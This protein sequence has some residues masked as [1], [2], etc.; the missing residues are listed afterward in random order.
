MLVVAGG[1]MVLAPVG[2]THLHVLHYH[3]LCLKISFFRNILNWNYSTIWYFNKYTN[4]ENTYRSIHKFWRNFFSPMLH[5]GRHMLIVCRMRSQREHRRKQVLR[6]TR[7]VSNIDT[8]CWH[9][10]MVFWIFLNL[11]EDYLLF[12]FRLERCFKHCWFC[13]FL[14]KY[15][16]YLTLIYFQKVTRHV[17]LHIYRYKVP[18]YGV[19]NS[20]KKV[21]ISYSKTTLFF[22]FFYFFNRC[23]S[24]RS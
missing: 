16:G 19:S 5:K 8:Y 21:I 22:F 20:W 2:Q 9:F 12:I 3:L 18:V 15:M 24:L 6:R 7:L 11:R 14:I 23:F 13:F 10:K 4:I 17:R 1:A